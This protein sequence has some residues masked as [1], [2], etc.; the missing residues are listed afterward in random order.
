M[1]FRITRQYTVSEQELVHSWISEPRG[2]C[3]TFTCAL[4]HTDLRAELLPL[5]PFIPPAPMQKSI[6][7]MVVKVR[8]DRA[9]KDPFPNARPCV[10]L[11][12]P[13]KKGAEM[14]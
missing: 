9:E 12:W 5:P 6:E 4:S 10:C 8:G 2:L 11:V 1:A 13:G 7:L 3:E 14:S